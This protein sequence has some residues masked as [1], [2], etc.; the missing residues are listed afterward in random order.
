MK[1]IKLHNQ[2]VCFDSYNFESKTKL[3]NFLESEEI[4]SI[5][6]NIKQKVIMVL[7]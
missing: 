2:T 5:L 6:E 7:G 3:K 1:T 4:K